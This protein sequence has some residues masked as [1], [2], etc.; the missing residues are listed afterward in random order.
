MKKT[1]LSAFMLAPFIT[2]A[3][4]FQ[5]NVQG[6]KAIG[7]G[8]AFTGI[9]SDASTVFFNPA[10]MTHLDGHQFSLGIN[11]I[12]PNVSLRTSE[13]ANIDQT[14][15]IGTPFFVYYSTS[16][17][18]EKL[19]NKLKF[20]IAI[21]NQFGSSA[22]FDDNWQGRN[23][24]QNM[25]LKTIMFQPTLAYKIHDKISVGAGFIFATGNFSTEKAVPVGSSNTTEGQAHLEGAGYGMG[26]NIGIYSQF[27]TL[28]E[29]GADQT[30]FAVGVDYRSE[31]S[32]ELNGGD[33]KFTDIPTSLAGQFPASTKFDT[34]LVLPAVF[35]AGLSVKHIKENWSL[36]FAYDLQWTG[37]SSYDSLNFNFENPETPDSKTFQD[38]EDVLTHRFGLD[39]TYKNKYSVRAGTYYDN[40]PMKDNRVSPHLPGITQMAYTF[41]LGYKVSEKLNIEFAYI[42][43]DAERTASFEGT[44]FTADYKRV[45]NVYTIGLNL[46]F[47]AGAKKA[48]TTP[49]EQPTAE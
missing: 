26:Y 20:G 18:K 36:E 27:L 15:G 19:D 44:G 45:V 13:N 34:K 22:S 5:L 31:L 3:G 9:G 16:I 48:A 30:K 43:Q 41:G 40:T 4:G 25:S 35:T 21:N 32:I 46:K 14:S 49:A 10:A 29:E 24:I 28:G 17:F 7:M 33:A 2:F 47:G 39:F 38:W 11:I 1:I 42:H 8:G 12:Q 6:L 37:W 23:I